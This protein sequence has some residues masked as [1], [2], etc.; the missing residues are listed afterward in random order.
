[1]VMRT[2]FETLVNIVVVITCCAVL[3]TLG[4]R[5]WNNHH[6]RRGFTL[7][8]EG[9][10]FPAFDG[11]AVRGAKRTLVMVLRHDCQYCEASAPFYRRLAATMPTTK[12]AKLV[13][14]TPDDALTAK[15][16]LR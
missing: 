14:V 2:R 1:N 16:Y 11:L 8:R 13:I 9:D 6:T 15:Q 4:A 10:T 5:A 12:L 3:A 7:L